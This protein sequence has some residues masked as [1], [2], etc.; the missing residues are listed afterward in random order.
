[1]AD[2]RNKGESM[3]WEFR[4][5]PE[6]RREWRVIRG[7]LQDPQPES[8]EMGIHPNLTDCGPDEVSCGARRQRAFRRGLPT[9][10]PLSR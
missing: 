6:H 7:G 3:D 10:R 4:P 2:P 8:E 1:M 5:G 9:D